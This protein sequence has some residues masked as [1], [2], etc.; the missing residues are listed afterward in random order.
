MRGNMP[1]FNRVG[2]IGKRIGGAVS[3]L[4]LLGIGWGILWWCGSVIFPYALGV[5]KFGFAVLRRWLS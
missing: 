2:D 5:L 4:V 1:I 3:G